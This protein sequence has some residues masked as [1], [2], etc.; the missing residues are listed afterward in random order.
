MD[1]YSLSLNQCWASKA[2]EEADHVYDSSLGHILLWDEF[3]PQFPW[4][5]PLAYATASLPTHV[6]K[7]APHSEAMLV[8]LQLHEKRHNCE[9]IGN[10]TGCQWIPWGILGHE[11]PSSAN[12]FP[13]IWMDKYC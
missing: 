11:R 10:W 3:C 5:G 4:V 2:D 6:S 13:S 7:F 9:L 8:K 1:D 12:S